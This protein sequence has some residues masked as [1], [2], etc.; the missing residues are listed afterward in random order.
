[1][2]VTLGPGLTVTGVPGPVGRPVVTPV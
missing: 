2:T 1:M